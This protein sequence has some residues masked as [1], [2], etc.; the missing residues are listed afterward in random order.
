MF[1]RPS[2]PWFLT[3]S[4]L[5][6]LLAGLVSGD[7]VVDLVFESSALSGMVEANPLPEEVDSSAEHVL[8]P[9][10]GAD[11]RMSGSHVQFVSP[12]DTIAI[13]PEASLS[14]VSSLMRVNVSHS[15]QARGPSFLLALRI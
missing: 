1:R 3:V 5:A 14:P 8:M 11:S 7:L 15:S 13:S 6:I 9:T 10:P 12:I 4:W 2:A